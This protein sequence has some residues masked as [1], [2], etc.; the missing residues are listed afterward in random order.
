[1]AMQQDA[2]ERVR[3]MQR[4]ARQRMEQGGTPREPAPAFN[5]RPEAPPP[6]RP[7]G[8]HSQSEYSHNGHPQSEYSQNRQTAQT[9]LAGLLQ[10]NDRV[11]LLLLLL[12]LSQ[13]QTD[14]A[15]IMALI[16]LML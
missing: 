4:R 7:M 12:L 6:G 1:M 15:L 14:P 13:E 2:A 5:G 9:P 3:E 11:I 10:D 16:W 8:D